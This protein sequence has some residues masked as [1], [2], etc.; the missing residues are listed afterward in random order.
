MALC[1]TPSH[2]IALQRIVCTR[3]RQL[4]DCSGLAHHAM[5]RSVLGRAVRDRRVLG[6]ARRRC[7]AS[8]AS[9]PALTHRTTRTCTGL[10]LHRG[11]TA[12][13][14]SLRCERVRPA[15]REEGRFDVWK[16]E[17]W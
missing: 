13:S 4:E 15:M 7:L 3:D 17:D 10:C 14:P 5:D 9:Q 12:L 16:A 11:G 8:A 2:M 1:R 6:S